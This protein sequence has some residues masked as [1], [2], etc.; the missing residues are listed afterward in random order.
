MPG[1]AER[2]ML[3]A[4]QGKSV[5]LGG[6]GVDFKLWGK[7][8]GG[9]LSVVEHPIQPGRL[10]PP[11]VH[12]NEDEYSYILQG[13]VGAR[14]GDQEIVAGPGSY[15]LKPRG[16][17][18]TF[19]NAGAEPARLIEMISP[20]GFENFFDELAEIYAAAGTGMPDQ[21]PIGELAARYNLTFVMEWAPALKE[22]YN[23]KLLG[24]P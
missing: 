19:W 24:E 13:E 9:L 3:A 7:E 2:F 21:L 8:T 1:D 6:L 23:L 22:K 12:A 10:V 11:H 16:I 20:A 14:I 5:W 17:P 18:H 15:V 4:E